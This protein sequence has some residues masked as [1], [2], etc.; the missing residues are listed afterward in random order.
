ME[1]SVLKS[2]LDFNS[3]LNIIIKYGGDGFTGNTSQKIKKNYAVRLMIIAYFLSC[4]G[5]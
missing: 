2:F 1:I 5:Y 3:D 4:F